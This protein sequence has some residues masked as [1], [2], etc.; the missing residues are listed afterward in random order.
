MLGNVWTWA[1]I[2]SLS[3]GF[4][5]FLMTVWIG[6]NQEKSVYLIRD[7]TKEIKY[8]QTGLSGL[9]IYEKIGVIEQ[10]LNLLS[11]GEDHVASSLLYDCLALLPVLQFCEID[12]ANNYVDKLLR[13]C[14]NLLTDYDS[15]DGKPMSVCLIESSLKQIELLDSIE[16]KKNLAENMKNTLARYLDY[17]KSQNPENAKRICNQ[18]LEEKTVSKILMLE[19][20]DTHQI[21]KLLEPQY[22]KIRK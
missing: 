9:E 3:A 17:L 6:K 22:M 10:G 14:L 7:L 4:I 16:N 19:S 13:E 15:R 8:L 18:F 20:G 2:I 1:D 21:M 11:Q 12:L 5:L